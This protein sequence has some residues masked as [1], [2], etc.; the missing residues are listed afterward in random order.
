MELKVIQGGFQEGRWQS[1]RNAFSDEY[2]ETWNSRLAQLT[3]RY[4][5]LEWLKP[6]I[7]EIKPRPSLTLLKPTN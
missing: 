2:I 6:Y 5:E 1:D 3:S 7:W 4:P